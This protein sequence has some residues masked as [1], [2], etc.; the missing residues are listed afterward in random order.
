MSTLIEGIKPPEPQECKWFGRFSLNYA[1]GYKYWEEK[2]KVK[3][4][5]L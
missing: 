2:N 5:P 4:S 3:L 1:L